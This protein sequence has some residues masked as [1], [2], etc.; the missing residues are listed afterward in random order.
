MND[1]DARIR[2]AL[3][4][5]ADDCREQDLRPAAPPRS[6]TII[7]ERRTIR[8]LAPMLAAAAV[9]AVVATSLALSGSPNAAHHVRP[10]GNSSPV[11]PP[12]STTT[13]T[14]SPSPASTTVEASRATTN[15]VAA[16]FFAD[17]CSAVNRPL[18]EPLW[19]FGAYPQAEQWETVDGPN[20]HSPWHID[21]NATALFF[22][23]GYL[24]FADVKIVTSAQITA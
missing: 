19:P 15:G 6:A 10:G 16:C 20:G 2:D 5:A 9:A 13:G 3:R 7:G 8:W 14:G 4:A 12:T 17:A 18:Y 11:H 1:I 22:T 23:Q 21:A 24:G